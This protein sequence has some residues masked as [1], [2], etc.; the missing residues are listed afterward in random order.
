MCAK[1]KDMKIKEIEKEL[2]MKAAHGGANHILTHYGFIHDPKI[3]NGEIELLHDLAHRLHENDAAFIIEDFAFT[4]YIDSY[5]G[6]C[7]NAGIKINEAI[8]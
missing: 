5:N 3:T 8:V 4:A 2:L 7:V 1:I 6:G